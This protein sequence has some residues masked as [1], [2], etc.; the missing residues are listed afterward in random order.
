M[1]PIKKRMKLYGF[2]ISI[3]SPKGSVRRWYDPHG[4]ESGSTPMHFDYGYIRRTEGT[5]GDHVDVYVGPDTDTATRVFIVDQMKKPDFKA[6]DEQK[7]MLGFRNAESAK[8]AY[9]KQY[10]DP[11]FFGSMREM[12]VEEFRDKVLDTANHGKKIAQ[13]ERVVPFKSKLQQRAAFGGHIPGISKEKAKEWAA[14]TDF[15][16]LPEKAAGADR[17]VRLARYHIG[18]LVREEKSDKGSDAKTAELAD[19]IDDAG[20]GLLAAPYVA[21][22]S[23][24]LMKGVGH[25]IPGRTGATITGAGDFLSRFGP[26]SAFG[27]SDLREAAGLALVAPGVTHAVAK[28]LA[29]AQT[30]TSPVSE[31]KLAFDV[32]PIGR[33][34]GNVSRN[35]GALGA[36]IREV[37]GELGRMGKAVRGAPLALADRA[38]QG[39]EA[40]GK[41]TVDRFRVGFEAAKHNVPES[42]VQQG[43]NLESARRPMPLPRSGSGSASLS[44]PTAV[45]TGTTTLAPSRTPNAV[46]PTTS[47]P[48][49]PGQGPTPALPAPPSAGAPKGQERVITPRRLAAAGLIGAGGVGLYGAK[50]GIDAVTGLASHQPEIQPY[51]ETPGPGRPF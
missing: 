50:Q 31:E 5:D 24:N 7:V 15:S 1:H 34:F 18:S 51:Y 20:I 14:E 32:A 47:A 43:V 3:E 12:S 9:L 25:Y 27:H 28:R 44:P 36:A 30:T 10:D 13:E 16:S 11:R 2:D 17:H 26:D 8:A 49:A 38:A 41:P 4:K 42:F 6:F 40:A 23:G 21:R 35:R 39:I 46:K 29:P 22:L 33:F 37:P 45:Q 48:V 19:R